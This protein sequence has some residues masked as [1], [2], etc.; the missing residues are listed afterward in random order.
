MT[1]STFLEK[2]EAAHDKH[3]LGPV[4]DPQ[5]ARLVLDGHVAGMEPSAS[6]TCLVSSGL[7]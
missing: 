5:V 6:K 1:S 3:V 4:D 7:L 2:I